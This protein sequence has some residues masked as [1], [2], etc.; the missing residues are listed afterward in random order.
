MCP[1]KLDCDQPLNDNALS[2]WNYLS[3]AFETLSQVKIP[4]CHSIL[5]TK[6]ASYELHSF[7]DASKEAYAAVVYLITIIGHESNFEASIVALKNMW[8]Q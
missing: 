4:R 6:H 7:S 8:H 3:K 5:G 1:N 2:K